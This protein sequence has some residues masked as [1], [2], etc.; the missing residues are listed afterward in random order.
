M[1]RLERKFPEIKASTRGMTIR[2]VL[3]QCG[4]TKSRHLR[5]EGVSSRITPENRHLGL[6]CKAGNLRP[7]GKIVRAKRCA[8]LS[9]GEPSLLALIT[10]A[11]MIR[12]DIVQISRNISVPMAPSTNSYVR[13]FQAEFDCASQLIHSEPG[14]AALEF[15]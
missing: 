8:G 3:T 12:F 9:R 7:F 6:N 5:D 1:A 11:K 14:A 10:N 13:L 15:L 4:C 2:R